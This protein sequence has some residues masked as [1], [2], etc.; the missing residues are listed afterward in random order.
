M[1]AQINPTVGDLRGNSERVQNYIEKAIESNAHI[2]IFP[3]LTITGYPPQ[4]LVL[5]K[6]FIEDN[7]KILENLA[8]MCK[9]I[10]AII[11]FIDYDAQH[12]YNAAA[13][14]RDKKIIGVV[15]KTLLPTYD[16][17]DEGR[18]FTPANNIEPI[19][20]DIDGT[21]IKAGIEICED[22]WDD[23]YP[24]KVTKK[25]VEKGAEI[26]INLSASPFYVGKRAE[27][28]HLLEI[29]SKK[30]C[31][32]I[33]Y[34]NMVGGQD[35]LVF[36]GF[37]MAFDSEG[38][39]IAFGKH[40]EEDF[41]IVDID[42]KNQ[43]IGDEVTPPKYIEEE[44]TFKALILGT[45]DYCKKTG[46]SR[47]V[48]GLS[49]GIDSS[50]TASIATEA[51]GKENILG[52]SMPSQYSSEHSK[53]DAKLLAKNLGIRH[54][55]VP[56]QGIFEAFKEALVEQF[57]DM[58]EDVTEENLQARI[59]GTILMA[60]SNKFGDIVFTTGNKTELALGYCT[61]YGDMAGG[62]GLISDLSKMQVYQLAEYYN[63]LKGQLIIPK[64]VLD[65]KPSAEL[66][67]DQYDPFD[68]S[69][70][71]PLVDEI[72]ENRK[73]RDE[74]I[75]KG[76]AQT[77]VDEVLKRIRNAEYKR[78]QAPPGIKITS[79]AF[80]IGRKMPIINKYF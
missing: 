45:R 55:V 64:R 25:L 34:V 80:G 40:F 38:K 36:D 18:Y 41:I 8:I 76:Y 27:R 71:S 11:G 75:E 74:L 47:A 62:L 37:S 61:L 68:Y 32:P 48:V 22:L 19:L 44:A 73:S 72:I 12:K 6:K 43:G 65:K 42:M 58:A 77:L 50:L 17:F 14:L 69:I 33:F 26:I 67:R 4:D 70:V 63:R 21:Q 49:G 78:K 56:I 13:V 51:L 53:E 16:V 59:R 60:L 79:K 57:K 46:F 9:D 5:E 30:N 7:K 23:S 35:E 24:I 2:V 28:E 52:V 20:I 29:H 39:M 66:K 15:Y 31:V 54:A 10:C 3:E 1:L